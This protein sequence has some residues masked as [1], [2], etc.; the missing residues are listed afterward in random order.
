MSEKKMFVF[1]L[2][3]L[4]IAGCSP[5]RDKTVKNI[6]ALEKALFSPDEYSFNKPRADSLVAMYETF[7][8]R[9]PGDTLTPEYLFKA[10]SIC[11]NAGE[12][13]RAIGYFDR[14]VEVSPAGYRAPMC[15]FFK[16]FIYENSLNNL[17]KAREI[18]LNFI[19]KYPNDPF[20]DDAKLA[21]MNIGK[22]P[23]QMVREFEANAR[24]DSAI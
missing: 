17:D 10:G 21:L 18:Y 3:T 19:E 14:C 7:V 4:L 24:P 22:T 6:S 11:M 5:S 12:H 1:M 16:A 23:E 20:T 15:M 8:E 9:F 13:A 2:L